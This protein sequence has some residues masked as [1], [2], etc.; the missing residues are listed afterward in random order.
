MSTSAL[1]L[2]ALNR[3]LAAHLGVD[4]AV[5]ART[6]LS[7]G[8]SQSTLLYRVT[9][10]DGPGIVVRI[11]PAVGPLEPYEPEAEARLVSWLGDAGLPVPAVELIEP[12]GEV[13]G[14]PFFASRQVFGEVI[15]DGAHGIGQQRRA[16][17]AQE[18]LQVLAGVHAVTDDGAGRL[19]WAP[20]KTPTAV[21]DRWEKSLAATALVLPAYHEYIG[22]WLVDHRPPEPAHRAVVHGDYRLA[23]VMW[24]GEDRISAVLDWEEA[25]LGDPYFDLGW[26]LMST[27][28]PDDEVMGL[29]PRAEFLDR[30]ADLT[31]TP[32]DADRLLWWEVAAGWSKMSMDAKAVDLIGAGQY[33]D[34]RPLLSCYTNRS[35]AA[36]VLRKVLRSESA[37]E[38]PAATSGPAEPAGPEGS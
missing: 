19:G 30:Y 20:L 4:P 28:G 8:L 21:L 38:T 36:L 32:V 1:D 18:Y 5:L 11:P 16:A 17:M 31:G 24:E 29:L 33:A 9:G 26:T 2:D 14:R 34:L 23:N 13:I 10:Q 7:G 37:G 6:L 35:V 3:H 22:R 12:T 25:G 27:F 15:L